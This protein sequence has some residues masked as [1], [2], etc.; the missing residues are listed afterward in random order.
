LREATG[1]WRRGL[2]VLAS[3]AVV[4]F[5]FAVVHPQGILAVPALMALAVGFSLAREWRGTLVPSMVGHGLN[6]FMVTVL[7]LLVAS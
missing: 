2:S 3:A 7:L 1:R 6:N 4:S 5:I